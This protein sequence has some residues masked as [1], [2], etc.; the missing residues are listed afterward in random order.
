MGHIH[1][2]VMELIIGM[3]DLPT[4]T[5]ALTGQHKNPQ[6]HSALSH[7]PTIK[8]LL[9]LNNVLVISQVMALAFILTL[10][11]ANSS[12]L[13]RPPAIGVYMSKTRRAAPVYMP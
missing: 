2:L 5:V 12:S 11:S 13:H 4:N 1:A 6:S 9:R 10:H 7:F 3:R 8:F